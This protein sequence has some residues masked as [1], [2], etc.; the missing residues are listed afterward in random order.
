ML[1]LF[2]LKP[3]N[4]ETYILREYTARS[5]FPLSLFLPLPTHISETKHQEKWPVVTFGAVGAA[6][7][8]RNLDGKGRT[9]LLDDVDPYHHYEN[10]TDYQNVFDPW[11]AALGKDIGDSCQIGTIDVEKTRAYKY[12]KEISGYTG[13]KLVAGGMALGEQP[14]GDQFARCRYFAHALQGIMAVLQDDEELLADGSTAGGCVTFEDWGEED[15]RCPVQS[16][17][18][19][20]AIIALIVILASLFMFIVCGTICRCGKCCCYKEKDC[21]RKPYKSAKTAQADME[22]TA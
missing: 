8:P 12:C 6:C 21:C 2:L 20:A 11:G 4:L 3:D 15:E 5:L 22:M 18:L 14:L 10:M 13:P 1:L 19:A 16:S 17:G 7:F 9:D